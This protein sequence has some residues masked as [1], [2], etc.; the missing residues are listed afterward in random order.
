M[1][2]P[3]IPIG[4]VVTHAGRVVNPPERYG[5]EN[6]GAEVIMRDAPL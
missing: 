3:P 6:K 2:P 4:Q 1:T 5:F